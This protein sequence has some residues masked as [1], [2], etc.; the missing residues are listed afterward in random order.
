VAAKRSEGAPREPSTAKS[1]RGLPPAQVVRSTDRTQSPLSRLPPGRLLVH[2]RGIPPN[3]PCF[4]GRTPSSPGPSGRGTTPYVPL[5]PLCGPGADGRWYAGFDGWC[6]IPGQLSGLGIDGLGGRRVDGLVLDSSLCSLTLTLRTTW[7]RLTELVGPLG[8][9]AGRRLVPGEDIVVLTVLPLQGE[10]PAEQ[11]EGAHGPEVVRLGASPP[12]A[13]LACP[14]FVHL[15]RCRRS[16]S[17]PPSG[18]GAEPSEA[19]GARQPTTSTRRVVPA[20]P[21]SPTQNDI[22]CCWAASSSF[23]SSRRKGT[24][25]SPV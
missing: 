18:G 4:P 1:S 16:H 7:S 21:S 19:E 5:D 17:P 9:C 13:S 3:T 8:S 25:T 24:E 10:V 15:G 12:P 11:A 23:P 14:D 22:A 6:R 20:E 2:Q